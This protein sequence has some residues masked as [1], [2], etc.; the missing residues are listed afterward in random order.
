MIPDLRFNIRGQVAGKAG[1]PSVLWQAPGLD[2]GENLGPRKDPT[3][4]IGQEQSGGLSRPNQ[5]EIMLSG[6]VKLTSSS[7][8]IVS[9]TR[10]S[11]VVSI[12][13]ASADG[14]AHLGR[15]TTR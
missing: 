8:K 3:V 6:Y 13:T 5:R 9:G 14:T 1:L 15:P 12:V 2:D 4:Q 7:L 10:I 11:S